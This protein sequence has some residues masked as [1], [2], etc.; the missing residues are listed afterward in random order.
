MFEYLQPADRPVIEGLEEHEIVLAK[1][2]PQ[3]RPLRALRGYTSESVVMSRWTFTTE[4]REAIA[5]GADVFLSLMTFGQPVQPVT[6]AISD[7]PNPEYFRE[8]LALPGSLAELGLD[9][10]ERFSVSPD[11]PEKEPTDGRT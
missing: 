1:D 3:Y 6:L 5:R 7:Q 11:K 10:T 9:V 8:T 2:Q 4:Q